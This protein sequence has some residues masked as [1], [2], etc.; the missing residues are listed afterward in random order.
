MKTMTVV[1]SKE[2]TTNHDKYFKLALNE[3]VYIRKDS[4]MFI[5]TVA[6]DKKKKYLEPDDDL[7]RAITGEE[8]KKRMH[9]VIDKFFNQIDER[10]IHT[11]GN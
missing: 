3:Q 4:N 2:F 6:N 7:R 5:V 10:N 8:L 9:V 1:S 11:G